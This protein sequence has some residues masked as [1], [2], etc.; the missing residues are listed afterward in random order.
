EELDRA[1]LALRELDLEMARIGLEEDQP[2]CLRVLGAGPRGAVEVD[3]QVRR[4][5]EPAKL[6]EAH[7]VAAPVVVQRM[8][9]PPSGEAKAAHQAIDIARGQSRAVVARAAHE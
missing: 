3:D 5:I 1:T 6:F 8:V 4:P 9:G 7:A 2:T